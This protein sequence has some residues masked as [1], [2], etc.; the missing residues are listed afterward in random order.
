[1]WEGPVHWE[2]CHPCA[3]D[4]ERHKQV[5]ERAMGSKP[6]SSIPPWLLLQYLAL[7]APNSF[8]DVDINTK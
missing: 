1:M 7:S 6:L 2:W 3:G 8:D 5:F 4:P